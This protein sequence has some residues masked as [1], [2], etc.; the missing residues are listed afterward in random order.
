MSIRLQ[1]IASISLEGHS[2]A[3]PG[4]RSCPPNDEPSE[5]ADS[6]LKYGSIACGAY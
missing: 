6:P 5:I 2:P 4:H 3:A 1:A